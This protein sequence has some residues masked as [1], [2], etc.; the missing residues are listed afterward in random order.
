MKASHEF[1]HTI[2]QTRDVATNNHEK[3]TY[4]PRLSSSEDPHQR[5]NPATRSLNHTLSA[6]FSICDSST[7]LKKN[8]SYLRLL[9]FDLEKSGR[10]ISLRMERESKWK[11]KTLSRNPVVV[12]G[13]IFRDGDSD[14]VA[15]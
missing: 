3:S 4:A 8:E 10:K 5:Y 6:T 2:N 13:S 12:R 11:I 1:R 15:S 9:A 7:T 14:L